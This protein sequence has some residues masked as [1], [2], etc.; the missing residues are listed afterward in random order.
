MNKK[1]AAKVRRYLNTHWF[2]NKQ[3]LRLARGVLKRY[4]PDEQDFNL[5]FFI[6][7]LQSEEDITANDLKE[8]IINE[9]NI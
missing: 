4:F 8:Y 6:V 9:T 2:V 1:I 5:K 7:D 3:E